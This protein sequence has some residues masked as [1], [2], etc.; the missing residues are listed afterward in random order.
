MIAANAFLQESI[1]TP[2]C[3]VAQYLGL[4]L[5]LQIDP[6]VGCTI[7]NTEPPPTLQAGKQDIASR[8]NAFAL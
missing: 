7:P 2:A 4:K 3:R 8:K 5:G 1:S 6:S